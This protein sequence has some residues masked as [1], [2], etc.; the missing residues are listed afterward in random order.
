MIAYTDF[1]CQTFDA[2][3]NHKSLKQCQQKPQKP[4]IPCT[5][6]INHL[7]K[8]IVACCL[9]VSVQNKYG[10]EKT[11][12]YCQSGKL[13]I[14]QKQSFRFLFQSLSKWLI[15]QK[16][17]AN[18]KKQGHVKRGNDLSMPYNMIINH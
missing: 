5:K 1:F 12:K 8:Q 6:C 2:N 10:L 16:I 15:F 4:D 9:P 18:D 7:M 11:Y 3:I 17:S 14:W 13:Q